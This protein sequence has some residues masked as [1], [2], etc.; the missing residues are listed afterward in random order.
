VKLWLTLATLAALSGCQAQTIRLRITE[1]GKEDLTR[2]AP[3]GTPKECLQVQQDLILEENFTEAVQHSRAYLI[4][5]SDRAGE[6]AAANTG[7]AYLMISKSGPSDPILA[8]RR[9]LAALAEAAHFFQLAVQ[10]SGDRDDEQT[11]R[12][13]ALL[14]VSRSGFLLRPAFDRFLAALGPLIT[15]RFEPERED[16]AAEATRL[17]RDLRRLHPEWFQQHRL[18]ALLSEVDRA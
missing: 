6:T 12:L 13:K 4:L 14:S 8:E 2:E 11:K 3:Y 9:L 7:L 17:L 18:D 15:F 1:P 16:Q 10:L 5:W